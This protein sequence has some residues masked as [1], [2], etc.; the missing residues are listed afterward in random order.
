MEKLKV[1][2]SGGGTGGHIFPALSIAGELRQRI[3]DCDILFVGALGRMEMEKVPA[4]GFPITGLPVMGFPRK[5]GVA[6]LKFFVMLW[7]SMIRARQIIRDFK[8]A[9]VIGVGGYASGPLLRAA[10]SRHIP[11]LIQE[12]NSYAGIT[13][14]LLG[15]RVNRICVAYEGMERFFPSEKIVLTGNPVRAN[16]LAPGATRRDALLH[17]GLPEEG[18][19][20]LITGGSLGARSLNEAVLA[21]LDAI[22]QAPWTVIWQTGSL[23][24][25]E[26]KDKTA[27]RLPGNLRIYQFLDRM[28]LAYLAASVV[29]SRAGAGT[30]SELCIAAKPVILVPSPNVAE[31]HQ[32]RNAMALA[33]REAAILISDAD[34]RERLFPEADLL[35]RDPAKRSALSGHI[36]QLAMPGATTRIVDEALQLIRS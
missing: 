24:F 29:I 4:A 14:K 10:I 26:M 33:S 15:K 22:G 35:M 36:S 23:Y 8:P 11:A 31:D 30:I 19:V 18:E 6:M 9:L 28:E 2:I 20:L 3:P 34:I 21:S 25:Q 7:R 16:L 27:G 5:P 12:Q 32:T 13:N 17:F 1:I